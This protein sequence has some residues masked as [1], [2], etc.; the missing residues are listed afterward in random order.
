VVE[1]AAPKSSPVVPKKKAEPL[2]ESP[3]FTVRVLP[4]QDRTTDESSSRAVKSFYASLLDGLRKV[5]GL[6]LVESEVLAS[7]IAP[8]EFHLKVTGDGPVQDGWSAKM[9]VTASLPV[10]GD[11]QGRR[12]TVPHSFQ[13]SSVAFPRCTGSLVDRPAVGC[14]DPEGG[15]A[16]QIELMRQVVFPPDPS[17]RQV[18]QARLQDRTL[19]PAQRLKALQSLRSFRAVVVAGP[20]APRMTQERSAIDAETLRGAVNLALTAP[21]PGIRAQTW[22]ALRAARLPELIQPLIDASRLE[23]DEATR[24]EAVTTLARDYAQDPKARAALDTLSRDDSRELVRMVARRALAGEQAWNDYAAARLQDESLPDAQRI[25]ALTYVAAS[26]ERDPQLAGLLDTRA[27]EALSVIVPRTLAQSGVAPD[28]IGLRNL[29]GALAS[30][31]Q[32][33]T[34]ALL[35][36]TLNASNDPQIRRTAITGLARHLDDARAREIVEYTAAHDADPRLREIAAV[37]QNQLVTPPPGT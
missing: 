26:A 30:S 15:A 20:T 11:T 17:L 23:T 34:V 12:A 25:E 8:A 35:I 19:D 22:E 36:S 13:Y 10:T 7:E 18:L 1:P 28:A 2:A 21:A 31:N 32:P 27:V 37:R 24:L 5:P 4:L 16:A 29:V 3:R 14:S 33:A 9:M 6:T